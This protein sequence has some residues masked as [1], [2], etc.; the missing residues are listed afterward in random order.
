MFFSLSIKV[1]NLVS[2]PQWRPEMIEK[3]GDYKLV[4]S[5]FPSIGKKLKLFWGHPEFNELMDE[6]LVYKRGVPREGFP[7]EV[8]FA[9]ST[10][11]SL[12][13]GAFPKLVRKDSTIWN[14][15]PV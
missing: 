7:A 10:L 12:H 4:N 8:L 5:A 13:K 6:L 11:E 15:G 3:I 1:Q 9:L 2:L 14:T